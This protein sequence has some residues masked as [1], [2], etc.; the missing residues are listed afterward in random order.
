MIGW[1]IA[2]TKMQASTMLFIVTNMV[3]LKRHSCVIIY[4]AERANV[5]WGEWNERSEALIKVSLV[6]GDCYEEIKC[7]NVLDN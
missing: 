1:N 4:Y 3:M 7:R 2:E 6:C 5:S